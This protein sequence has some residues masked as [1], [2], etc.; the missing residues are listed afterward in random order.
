MSVDFSRLSSNIAASRSNIAALSINIAAL[1]IL[2]WKSAQ[3]VSF[4]VLKLSGC[5]IY[6][7][8]TEHLM[9]LTYDICSVRVEMSSHV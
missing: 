6:V 4:A 1:S 3:D 8:M 7:S 2:H 9:T 5:E